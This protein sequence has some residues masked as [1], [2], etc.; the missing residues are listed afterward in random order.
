[1]ALD[2]N[3]QSLRDFASEQSRCKEEKKKKAKNVVFVVLIIIIVLKAFRQALSEDWLAVM[4]FSRPNVPKNTYY[5]TALRNEVLLYPPPP[6]FFFFF[7]VFCLLSF[8]SQSNLML[9][10]LFVSNVI[11]K[12]FDRSVFSIS[13]KMFVVVC[14]FLAILFCHVCFY[15]LLLALSV[16]MFFVPISLLFPI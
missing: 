10:L 15:F 14:C 11:S 2:H 8:F 6:F 4:Q 16:R 5:D 12:G 1:M 13:K 3:F 7:F 9:K